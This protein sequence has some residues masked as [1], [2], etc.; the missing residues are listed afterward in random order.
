MIKPNFHRLWQEFPDHIQFKTMKDLY[1]KLGGAAEKNIYLPGFGPNGNTC[2]SR[3]SVAFNKAGAPINTALAGTADARTLGTKDGSRIIYRVADFRSYLLKLLGKPISDDTAPYDDKF[4]GK[5]GIIAFSVNWSGATGHIALWNGVHYRE[6]GYD[7]YSN[8]V[9]PS[10][11]AIKTSR[12]EFW[13]L[14]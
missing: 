6:P 11:P 10:N 1:T 9:E 12:S 13:E 5:K 14:A 2:A 7:N 4:R 3:L 8:Y